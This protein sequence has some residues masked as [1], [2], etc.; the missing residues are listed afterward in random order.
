MPI[1]PAAALQQDKDGLLQ[2]KGPRRPLLWERGRQT[3]TCV[4]AAATTAQH[5][6]SSPVPE[7][8]SFLH[9]KQH[10]TDGGA[11]SC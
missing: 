3:V 5:K 4:Q 2:V 1:M 11:E 8:A 9:G 6:L 10:T 7:A